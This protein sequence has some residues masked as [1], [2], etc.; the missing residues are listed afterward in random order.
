MQRECGE[1]I[2]IDTQRGL[3]EFNEQ[4]E[5]PTYRDLERERIHKKREG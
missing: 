3:R 5:C 4:R 2:K 1:Y